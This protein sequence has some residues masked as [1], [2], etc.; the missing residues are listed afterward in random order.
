M[1][2]ETPDLFGKINSATKFPDT[3]AYGWIQWKG[4]EV[5]IDLHCPCGITGHIDADFF[6]FYEC[7]CGQR[8]GV[9]CYVKLVPLTKEES[10]DGWVD[11]YRDTSIELTPE[12]ASISRHEKVKP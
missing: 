9:G 3:T 6:Y 5:C 11:F 2:D 4:T 10:R 1:S 7:R 8:Y 12:G